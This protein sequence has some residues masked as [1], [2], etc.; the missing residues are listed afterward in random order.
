MLNLKAAP[1]DEKVVNLLDRVRAWARARP[2]ISA[3]ALA[4]S[5]AHG[6]ARPDSDVDLVILSDSPDPLRNG[7]WVGTFGTPT[8]VVTQQWGV[9][10]A[11][12]VS[13]SQFG[14]VEIGI[15]PSSWADVPVDPGTREVVR[16]GIIAI[17]DPRGALN[18][19]VV[20]VL[21]EAAR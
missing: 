1:I 8:D 19:L 5:H 17:Y 20:E 11:H 18:R 12:R 21:A 16:D 15:A 3:V 9:L 13:Y 10:T 7:D 2:D 6:R 4:G 14:E